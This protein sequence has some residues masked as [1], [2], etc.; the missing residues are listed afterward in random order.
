MVSVDYVK[1]IIEKTKR[2]ISKCI[3]RK[4]YDDALSLISICA[5]ILYQT[6]IY[7]QDNDLEKALNI[8]ARKLITNESFVSSDDTIIFYD[9]FGLNDRGLA[10]I[11]LKALCKE[12]K[13]V[14]VTYDDRKEYIPDIKKLI[15]EHNGECEYISRKNKNYKYQINCLDGIVK[16]YNSKR[17][18]FY[19]TPDDVVATSVMFAY[20]GLILRYQINLTDH[21]FWLGAKCI[22]KCIE[23]RNYGANISYEY[24]KIDKSKIT[25]IPF[26]PR[27][28]KERIFQ[29]FPFDKNDDQKVVFSGGALY[30]TI[31]EDNK[32]Y[33]I[34][35][36]ILKKHKNVVFWYAGTGDDTRIK[37]IIEKYPGRIF[38]TGER[39]DLFQVL[40]HCDVYLS[41]YPLPGGLM[42]QYSAIAGRV[43]V[44]LKSGEIGEDFLI[45]Q[46]EIGV[47]FDSVDAVCKE[48]DRLLLDDEYRNSRC[49]IMKKSVI[50]PDEFEKEVINVV[51]GKGDSSYTMSVRHLDTDKVRKVY[52]ECASKG[53]I[54]SMLVRRN[55][56]RLGMV[57]FPVILIRGIVY[58]LIR[59][60]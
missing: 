35:E 56:L 23:F 17:F 25:I 27:I 50:S 36:R 22:D 5:S 4:K 57:Y 29:G 39:N 24:R 52:L 42:Y 44:T 59:R 1:K 45:N 7:Y 48:M 38:I 31:S 14:Y 32:Y 19:S 16:K 60:K 37:K 33:L 54:D 46:K 20:R 41:T 18:V 2:N 43:P 49:S 12:K 55:S 21:A 11:Y 15:S 28:D 6:N 3:K 53:K 13:V 8:I 34:I 58:K 51:F 10:L 40:V 26:Y 47:E 30:K 9:G